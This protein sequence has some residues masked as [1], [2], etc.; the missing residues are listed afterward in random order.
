MQLSK[1]VLSLHSPTSNRRSIFSHVYAP[2]RP[3][4]KR[5][6]C[7]GYTCAEVFV[8]AQSSEEKEGC[9]LL[10]KQSLF[11]KEQLISLQIALDLLLWLH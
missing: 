1:Q 4:K 5:K 9:I 11:E 10:F 8:T 2:C 7:G 3:Q 6:L